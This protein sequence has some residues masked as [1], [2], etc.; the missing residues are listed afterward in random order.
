MAAIMSATPGYGETAQ[1]WAEKKKALENLPPGPTPEEAE[2]A[3][4]KAALKVFTE[5]TDW[6]KEMREKVAELTVELD[7]PEAPKFDVPES[8]E[9]EK[10]PNEFHEKGDAL[11]R[12]GNFLGSSK[13]A[14]EDIAQK[15]V[16]LLQQIAKNTAPQSDDGGWPFSDDDFPMS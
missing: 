15:Q 4:K 9:K 11:L 13:N 10:K 12:V 6:L 1:S 14:L 7:N 5:W 16:A 8:D 3:A 2:A